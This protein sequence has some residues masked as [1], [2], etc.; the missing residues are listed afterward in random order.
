MRLLLAFLSGVAC[1]AVSACQ[2]VGTPASH[3]QEAAQTIAEN[4]RFG[5]SELVMEKVAPGLRAAFLH[6]HASWGGRITIADTE[7][8]NFHMPDSENAGVDLRVTW[9]DAQVQELR[10]TLLRQKWHSVQGAWLLVSEDRVD[11]DIGLMGEKVEVEAPDQ[12]PVKAQFKTI[13]IG[14]ND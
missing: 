4:E 5:R 12:P 6:A 3:A 7:L 9:Y 1:L 11:G 14:A 8:G 13:R 10:S 2:G